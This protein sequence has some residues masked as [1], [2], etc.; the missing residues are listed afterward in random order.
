MSEDS[1]EALD[2]EALDLALKDYEGA[3][4]ELIPVLQEVQ[5]ALGY[6]PREAMA[7][8]AEFL[9]IPE[10]AVYGVATFYSQFYLTRQGKHKIRVCQGTACHV[11]GSSDVVDAV[12]KRLGLKAGDDTTSD[13]EFTLERVACVG[14]CAL[15]PVV[16]VDEKVYGAMSAAK[17]EAVIDA[18]GEQSECAGEEA[19]DA[20]AGR[21]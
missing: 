10:S 9:N 12:R 11:R 18:M 15:A 13:H 4:S 1:T 19:P 8:V 21:A 17:T 2:T 16:V 20:R 14:S 5:D 6:L 3:P 7:A